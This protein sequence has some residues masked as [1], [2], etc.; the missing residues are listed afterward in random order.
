MKKSFMVLLLSAVLPYVFVSE[1]VAVDFKIKG[2]WINTFEYGSGGNFTGRGRS[3]GGEKGK[4]TYGWGLYGQDEFE[5]KS[6]VRVQLDAAVSERLSGTVYFEMGATTW[7]QDRTGGA[8]GTDGTMVKI[9]QAYLDWSLPNTDVR[10]R[11]GL[12]RIYLPDFVTDASQVFDADTAGIV[13]SGKYNDAL[14][15]S[16]FWARPYND[17]WEGTNSSQANY[18]DN[19]D[20]WGLV[21]P[22]SLDGFKVTPWAM[23]GMAGTHTFRSGDDFYGRNASGSGGLGMAPA[24]YALKNSKVGRGTG[25]DYSMAFWGGITGEITAWDPFRFAWSANYGGIDT[26]QSALNRS[27]WYASALAEYAFAWGIPGV[28]GWYSSGDDGNVKNGSERMPS[29]EANNEST[30]SVAGFG[31]LGTYSLGRDAL[32]GSTL[33]GTW[34]VGARIKDVS[35]IENLKHTFHVNFYNGTNSPSM[36]KYIKGARAP[37]GYTMFAPDTGGA[38]ADFNTAN[39]YGL[40]LTR[41]DYAAEFGIRTQYQIYENLR[42]LVE[43]NYVALW[44]DQSSSVWGGY[45]APTGQWVGSNSIKDAWNVNVSFIYRF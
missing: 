36:A 34:G 13:L 2:I 23:L 35:V 12:Q 42:F 4:E 1:S 10:T 43:S 39:Y 5:A 33:V 8:L 20:L 45:L 16:A 25:K 44:L 37:W 24:V 38:S 19:F 27:G 9:K 17:N 14:A 3:Q 31:T 7:G 22:V 15:F 29:I 21:V 40:Y 26:G 30:S 6:R 11:M 41:Q 32:L 18:L 28:Y